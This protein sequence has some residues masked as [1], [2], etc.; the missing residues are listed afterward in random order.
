MLSK[1]SELDE[2]KTILVC[3]KGDVDG[4]IMIVDDF[5][6]KYEYYKTLEN[7]FIYT[8]QRYDV[9]LD[10]GTILNEGMKTQELYPYWGENISKDITKKD[11]A[12]IQIVLDR[13]L[14]KNPEKSIVYFYFEPIKIDIL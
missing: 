6:S 14:A 10:A 11:K 4:T 12:E 9:T 7:L 2:D 5:K 13:I 8:A 1:L 3:H